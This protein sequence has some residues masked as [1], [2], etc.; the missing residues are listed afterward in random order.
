MTDT[1]LGELLRRLIAG[2]ENEVVEFK[3]AGADFGTHDLGKYFSALSNEANLHGAD[4]GWL[5][6]GVDDKTRQ[7]VG[8]DY[9][10]DT[11]RLEGLK[12][13]GANRRQVW[14]RTQ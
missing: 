13:S 4:A 1:E 7:I 10:R 12:C 3:R 9:R 6:F 2:W 14:I 8:S 5:V 11:E